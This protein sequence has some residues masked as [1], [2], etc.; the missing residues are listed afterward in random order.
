MQVHA[1]EPPP[2]GCHPPPPCRS[3]AAARRRPRRRPGA[4]RSVRAAGGPRAPPAAA[5][6]RARVPLAPPAGAGRPQAPAR[7]Q[8]RPGAGGAVCGAGLPPR[9]RPAGAAWLRGRTAA[10]EGGSGRGERSWRRPSGRTAQRPMCSTNCGASHRQPPH[11][12]QAAR[13]GAGRRQRLQQLRRLV[14][15]G[16]AGVGHFEAQLAH[17]LGGRPLQ[18]AQ[19][20]QRALQPGLAV[21]LHIQRPKQLGAAG[22]APPA[23]ADER[24]GGMPAPGVGGRGRAALMLQQLQETWHLRG[25]QCGAVRHPARAR[26]RGRRPGGGSGGGGGG[27]RQAAPCGRRARTRPSGL[28]CL[29]VLLAARNRA[30]ICRPPA[31]RSCS[32][33]RENTRDHSSSGSEPGRP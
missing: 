4:A 3:P 23:A 24:Q 8:P 10:G 28:G 2:A 6:R 29:L 20:L 5:G 12:A 14:C 31:H 16:A 21:K 26:A 19:E 7:Q 13:G 17:V 27:G 1:L 25:E 30:V 32:R 18:P 9:R 22:E 15:I 11:L 33:M